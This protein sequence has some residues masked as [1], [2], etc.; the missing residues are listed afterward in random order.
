MDAR[1][2]Y[3]R[4]EL[5]SITIDRTAIA[6]VHERVTYNEPTAAVGLGDFLSE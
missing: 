4:P 6:Q 1:S 3:S 5:L 2:H